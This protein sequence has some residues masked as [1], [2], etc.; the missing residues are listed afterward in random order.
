VKTSQAGIDL[1]K[2]FEGLRLD[3]YLCSSSIPTIG[4]GHT[5]PDVSLG[6][7]ITGQK[8]EI[9]LRQDLDRFEKAVEKFRDSRETIFRKEIET[10]VD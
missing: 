10:L 6:M 5:G 8:A 3:S 4:Y 9:L 1:I 7:R 2:T